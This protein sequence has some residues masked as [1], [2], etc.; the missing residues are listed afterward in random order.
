MHL[1]DDDI[2]I[3]Q[4]VDDNLDYENMPSFDIEKAA[5]NQVDQRG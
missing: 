5:L 4:V 3:K 1:E 2:L